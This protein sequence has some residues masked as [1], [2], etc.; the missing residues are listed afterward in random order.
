MTAI[1]ATHIRDFE[2][3]EIAMPLTIGLIKNTL[4]EK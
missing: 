4:G 2:G 1:A 3:T